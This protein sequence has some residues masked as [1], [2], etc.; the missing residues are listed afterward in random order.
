MTPALLAV[1]LSVAAPAPKDK[2]APAPA[3][4]G[5][6]TPEGLTVG[7]RP[8]ATGTDRFAFRAD[9]TWALSTAGVES[10]GGRFTRDPGGAAG[11]IDLMDGRPGWE[12]NLCRY[13]VDADTL[14]LAVGHS[15]PGG[16]PGWTRAPG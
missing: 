11:T 4:A 7:G 15:R 10:A 5:E 9:G 6:W 1:A 13:R 2:P 8:A 3:L 12:P 14:I 16:R